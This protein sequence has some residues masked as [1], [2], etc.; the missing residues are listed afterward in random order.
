FTLLHSRATNT[1][2]SARPRPS[3]LTAIPAS[4]RRPVHSCAVNWDPW[5]V[6]KIS[7]RLIA[8]ASSSA[9]RQNRPL[10]CV[11]QAPRQHV[12]AEPVDHRGQVHEARI[13]KR[14]QEPIIDLYRGQEEVSYQ[15]SSLTGVYWR[16]RDTELIP[17]GR[18]EVLVRR[19]ESGWIATT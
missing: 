2:S 3:R 17:V 16:P 8:N 1:L 15:F 11:R 6:L 13:R 19:G 4:S 14:D 5:S 9:S 10:E 12:P 18:W 7:G